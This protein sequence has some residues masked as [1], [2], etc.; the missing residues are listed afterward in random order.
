MKVLKV[1]KKVKKSDEEKELWQ[2]CRELQKKYFQKW[3]NKPVEI[4]CDN[5]FGKDVNIRINWSALGAVSIAETKSFAN[6]LLDAIKDANKM[7][8]EIKKAYPGVKVNK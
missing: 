6:D 1:V 2:F 7:E 3:L 8:A 5:D 4:F